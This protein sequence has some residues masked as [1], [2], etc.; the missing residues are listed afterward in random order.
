VQQQNDSQGRKQLH[1]WLKDRKITPVSFAKMLGTSYRI[2]WQWL[3]GR[4]IPG[5][6]YAV[7]VETITKGAIKCSS[8][9]C[10]D[11]L[12]STKKSVGRPRLKS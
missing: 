2:V 6:E 5:L 3:T 12:K 7:K 1:K 10:P 4:T 11:P 8:W 9:L